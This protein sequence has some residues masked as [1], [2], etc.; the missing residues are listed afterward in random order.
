[1]TVGIIVGKD[2]G[3]D[4]AGNIIFRVAVG[5]GSAIGSGAVVQLHAN[6]M[7]VI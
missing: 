6:K 7:I 3:K 1:M 2:V 4:V 5:F